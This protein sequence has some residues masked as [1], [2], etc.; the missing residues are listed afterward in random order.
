[1]RFLPEIRLLPGSG[2]FSLFGEAAVMLFFIG[3][4]TLLYVT[5]L[6]GLPFAVV[7]FDILAISLLI[8]S[9]KRFHGGL[10][11]CWLFL[12][13]I[14]F[15]QGGALFGYLFGDTSDPFTITLM[16]VTPFD[17]PGAVRAETLLCIAVS[18]LFVYLPCAYNLTEKRYSATFSPSVRKVM[19]YMFYL[20]LPFEA[21]KVWTYIRF[22]QAHGGYAAN[23]LLNTDLLSSVGLPI[24]L[25]SIVSTCAFYDIL[26][27]E[28]QATRLRYVYVSFLG[29]MLLSLGIGDR[30]GILTLLVMIWYVHKFK[31]QTRFNF[32]PLII[33]G[34]L[35]AMLAAFIGH[36][37]SNEAVASVNI[38][39]FVTGQGVSM[40][41]TELAIAEKHLFQPHAWSYLM[42][43]SR[44]FPKGQPAGS[45]F[46][47]D[48]SMFLSPERVA[49]GQG[50]GS[51]YIGEA[52]LLGGIPGVVL[53]SL[54]LGLLLRMIYNLSD[55]KYGFA[56]TIVLLP[57]LIFLPRAEILSFLSRGMQYSVGMLLVGAAAVAI[58]RY[59]R[60]LHR[61][62]AA[63]GRLRKRP[64]AT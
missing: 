41:V 51:S 47:D 11:P 27:M 54:G 60:L 19:L 55:R 7:S 22:V 10:H 49:E 29:I 43:G 40:Q 57:E 46:N 34:S 8:L 37:R 61:W 59:L 24:R 31:R 53:V 56:V 12:L 32:V 20:F 39:H 28:T 14:T 35:G 38:L 58:D 1:M 44:L 18:M 62:P 5:R 21:Y 52:Y 9:W 6:V 15:F 42:H 25:L 45:V 36:T 30:G 17:V 26:L 16:W 23:L 64:A 2:N 33:V 13:A 4:V 48:V 3:S 50:T 63:A